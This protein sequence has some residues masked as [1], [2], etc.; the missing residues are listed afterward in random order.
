MF[1]FFII[2]CAAA[3]Y[4]FNVGKSSLCVFECFAY[5]VETA[6]NF[7]VI[8]VVDTLLWSKNLNLHISVNV[9]LL[10]VCLTK[11]YISDFLYER[12]ITSIATLRL[13]KI[14]L[15]RI[16]KIVSERILAIFEF[17][18]LFSLNLRATYYDC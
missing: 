10:N 12:P 13:I 15:Q 16:H 2:V 18:S 1:F 7:F 9:Y 17:E 5:Q 4:M 14:H 11:F 8:F 3:F 6:C